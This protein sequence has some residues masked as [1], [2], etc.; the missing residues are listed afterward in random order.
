MAE[1][2]RQEIA[3]DK[4]APGLTGRAIFAATIGNM[5]EFYDFITYA[6]FAIQIGHAFFPV[7]QLR[8]L[9]SC[10]RWRPSAPGSSPG[11]SAALVIGAYSD[12]AGRRPAM[13]LSFTMMGVRDHRAGAHAVLRSDRHRRADPGHPRAHG[14]GLLARRRGG[15][16][17]AY[18]MEAAAAAPARACRL[19][20][21]RQPANRRDRRRVRRPRAFGGR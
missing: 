18:L 16:T 3:T 10:C 4:Q 13:M 6:F 11:R 1:R 8:S 7:A 19:V 12:R 2:S 15:P 5:L 14:A 17:T 21:G 20:A 9:A